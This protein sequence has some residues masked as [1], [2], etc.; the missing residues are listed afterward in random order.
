L[1]PA[2]SP[3][4]PDGGER[5]YATEA[6]AGLGVPCYAK[7]RELAAPPLPRTAAP[8]SAL[9]REGEYGYL[10]KGWG[11]EPWESDPRRKLDSARRR[12]RKAMCF[13]V[14]G[15]HGSALAEAGA[16]LGRL[17]SSLGRD[18]E[19]ALFCETTIALS[20]LGVCAWSSADRA[21]SRIAARA[22]GKFGPFHPQALRAISFRAKLAG[23]EG[24][25]TLSL[26]LLN[27]L[28]VRDMASLGAWHRFTLSDAASLAEAYAAEG[29]LHGGLQAAR[30]AAVHSAAALGPHHPLAAA[31]AALLKTRFASAE[32]F[33][34]AAAEL[35]LAQEA[36]KPLFDP[37]LR[38]TWPKPVSLAFAVLDGDRAAAERDALDE[39]GT[40]F[41]RLMDAGPLDGEPRQEMLRRL[42]KEMGFAVQDAL[43]PAAR[44][45]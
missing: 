22:S 45:M 32:G 12:S 21:L 20:G 36:N 33:G 25:G 28:L 19:E 5:D 17:R 23:C 9:E 24:R 3:E 30:H 41:G 16:A 29:D 35:A 15:D 42:I 31:A 38:G 14:A 10:S 44:A 27:D 39:A 6:A 4:A 37:R 2:R 34:A 43:R 13:L 7:T 40:P 1:E 8:G 11:G 26:K 18:S